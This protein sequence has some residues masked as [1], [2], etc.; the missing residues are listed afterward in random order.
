[1]KEGAYLNFCIASCLDISI[2]SS[3]TRH[4]FPSPLH[5]SME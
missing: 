3:V 2:Q 1:M 5:L 4:D